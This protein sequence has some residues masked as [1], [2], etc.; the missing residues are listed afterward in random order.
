MSCCTCPNDDCGWLGN[1]SVCPEC[2]ANTVWDE[3][4]DDLEIKNE[5]D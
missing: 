5:E 2:G 1:A 3:R 4:D